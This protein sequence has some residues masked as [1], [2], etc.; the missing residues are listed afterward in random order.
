MVAMWFADIGE[1]IAW[2]V[3]AGWALFATVVL[4]MRRTALGSL[5]PAAVAPPV[6]VGAGATSGLL[7]AQAAVVDH[8]ADERVP[9][10]ADR[11]GWLWVVDPRAPPLTV[12]M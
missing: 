5:V 4:A 8:V 7:V 12:R 6:L 10:G 2:S 9:G 1:G 11:G 3:A